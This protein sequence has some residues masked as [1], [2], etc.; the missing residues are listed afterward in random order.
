MNEIEEKSMSWKDELAKGSFAHGYYDDEGDIQGVSVI[1]LLDVEGFITS[2]LKKQ[3]ENCAKTMVDWED[4]NVCK[5]AACKDIWS[6]VVNA[7]EPV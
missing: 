4:H 3:R 2:L 5:C 1:K 7:K 6:A